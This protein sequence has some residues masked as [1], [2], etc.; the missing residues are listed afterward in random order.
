[1]TD[2]A[3]EDAESDPPVKAIDRGA[4]LL[5]ALAAY[6]YEGAAFT[7]LARDTAFGKATT[8]RLLAALVDAGFVFQDVG[9]R[10]YRLGSAVTLLGRTARTQRI[11]AATQGPLEQLASET[12]DTVFAYVPEGPAAVCI[13]RATGSFPIRTLTLD[14][15]DRRPLGVG[16][17]SL[18]LLAAM[19]ADEIDKVLERNAR[20]LRDFANHAPDDIRR[21]VAEARTQGY[22]FNPGTIVRGMCAVGMPVLDAEGRPLVSLS[23]A[24]ISERMLPARVAELAKLI[25]REVKGLGKAIEASVP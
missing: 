19:P 3:S 4:R 15:G 18:A 12:A 5:R 23:V 20:W 11:A 9:T 14:V 2:S 17:G 8:H 24:A 21:A 7:D 10:R 25:R 13:G 16:A 6:P 22:A 1:M